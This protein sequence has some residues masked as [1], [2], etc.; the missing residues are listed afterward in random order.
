M[1]KKQIFSSIV[2]IVVAFALYKYFQPP[3][4][5]VPGQTEVEMHMSFVK[6]GIDLIIFVVPRFDWRVWNWALPFAK[7]LW[8]SMTIYDSHPVTFLDARTANV[9]YEKNGFTLMHLESEVEDYYSEEGQK[10]YTDE[11]EAMLRKLH[12]EAKAFLNTGYLYRGGSN[13]Q[14]NPPA[15]GSPHL[16]YWQNFTEYMEELD[17]DMVND[18]L[19]EHLYAKLAEYDE[20]YTMHS[21]LGVWKPVNMETP[22]CDF[23]FAVGDAMNFRM[24]HCVKNAL[25]M[26]HFRDGMWEEFHVATAGIRYDADVNYYYYPFQT[27]EEVLVFRQLTREEFGFFANPHVAFK[28]DNCPEGSDTRKSIETRVIMWV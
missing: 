22:V 1:Q 14:A 5:Y 21:V 13:P 15:V 19:E 9:T 25:T 3:A 8:T 20:K 16:D 2:V 24:E 7:L 4:P 11:I 23:P 10:Q 6:S 27:N 12:P 28:N 18:D 26:G 17:Y